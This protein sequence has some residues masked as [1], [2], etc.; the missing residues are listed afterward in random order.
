MVAVVGQDGTL[1]EC[2]KRCYNDDLSNANLRRGQA[3]RCGLSKLCN[4]KETLAILGPA[5]IVEMT[6]VAIVRN[7]A[8]YHFRLVIG[9]VIVAFW[10]GDLFFPL[11]ELFVASWLNP[12]RWPPYK[13]TEAEKQEFAARNPKRLDR[14]SE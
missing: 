3:R 8:T 5:M 4:D 9:C 2:M 6:I 14:S 10:L 13:P 12:R 1:R 7:V 11:V